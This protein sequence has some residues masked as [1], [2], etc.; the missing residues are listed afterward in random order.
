MRKPHW[1]KTLFTL[2][3]SSPCEMDFAQGIRNMDLRH[4][5]GVGRQV[6]ATGVVQLAPFPAQESCLARPSPNPFIGSHEAGWGGWHETCVSPLGLL[7]QEP[8]AKRG[9]LS[10]HHGSVNFPQVLPTAL[11]CSPGM[12]SE[13]SFLSLSDGARCK[14]GTH[15]TDAT[16]PPPPHLPAPK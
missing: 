2:P 10:V 9:E 1:T 15:L 7:S 13:I 6:L 12:Y 5:W 4:P 11:E 16:T 8:K 14:G 3:R